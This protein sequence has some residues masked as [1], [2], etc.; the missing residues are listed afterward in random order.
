M[1]SKSK[2]MYSD[3]TLNQMTRAQLI[4]HIKLNY[5][6]LISLERWNEDVIEVNTKLVALLNQ[7]KIEWIEKRQSGYAIKMAENMEKKNDR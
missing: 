2:Y 3:S 5:I 7:H 6:N 4:E 1:K